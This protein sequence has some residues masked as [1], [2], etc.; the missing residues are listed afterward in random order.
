MQPGDLV[1]VMRSSIIVPA[2]TIALIV[3][4][5]TSPGL[6]SEDPI[7]IWIV[8]LMDGMQRRYLTRDLKK[9]S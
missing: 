7:E 9:I 3:E 6:P 8:Q 4:G 2:G 5:H 1:R